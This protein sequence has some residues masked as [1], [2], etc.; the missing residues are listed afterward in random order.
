[1]NRKPS[2]TKVTVPEAVSASTEKAAAKEDG[3]TVAYKKVWE[4]FWNTLTF[5]EKS[6]ILGSLF[7]AACAIASAGYWLGQEL[8]Q[9]RLERKM[10]ES[11]AEKMKLE[12]K[13]ADYERKLS[14][15][16]DEREPTLDTAKPANRTYITFVDDLNVARGK[17]TLTVSTFIDQYRGKKVKWNCTILQTNPTDKWYRIG[18]EV[19]SAPENQAFAQFRSV[20]FDR[21]AKEGD[22]RIVEGVFWNAD[23]GGIVLYDCRFVSDSKEP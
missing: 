1:M 17:G 16:D 3:K 12:N 13:I 10:A 18:A 22:R 19:T 5:G 20:E 23:N 6:V 15:N 4:F 11:V 8:S 9:S 14:A 2:Q 21:F 7:L